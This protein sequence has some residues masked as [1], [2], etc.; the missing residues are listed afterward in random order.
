MQLRAA[1]HD[2]NTGMAV[3][4]FDLLAKWQA[5]GYRLEATVDVPGTISHRGGIIDIFPPHSENPVR[6]EFFG[7]NIDS[8][9]LFDP[10][11]QRSIHQLPGIRVTPATEFPEMTA[12]RIA[13]LQ[14]LDLTEL[15]PESRKLFESEIAGLIAGTNLEIR[16]FYAPLFNRKGLADYFNGNSL[17]IVDEPETFY[18]ALEDL[19]GESGEIRGR[20]D[21]I[22]QTPRQF[23]RSLFRRS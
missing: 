15:E 10:V 1:S 4:P 6:I 9:R 19:A 14:R 12:A 17:V 11:S 22:M 2:I 23:P 7:N 16:Q 18:N 3:K 20:A 8:I 13:E 5:I 21:A